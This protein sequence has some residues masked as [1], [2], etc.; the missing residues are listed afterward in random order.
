MSI[1]R[2]TVLHGSAVYSEHESPQGG[3]VTQLPKDSFI[4][5]RDSPGPDKWVDGVMRS[6]LWKDLPSETK[7]LALLLGLT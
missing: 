4:Y 7:A 1:A 3:W 5:C 2:Y 6:V